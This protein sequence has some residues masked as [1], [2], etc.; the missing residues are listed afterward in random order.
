MLDT[1]TAIDDETDAEIFRAYREWRD[2]ILR[3]AAA[4]EAEACLAR[5]FD[6]WMFM[7]RFRNC[8]LGFYFDESLHDAIA[9][10]NPRRFDT[11]HL[12]RPKTEF[13]IA[14]IVSN[15]V[16]T[17]GASVPHRFMLE[18]PSN[19][20]IQFRQ[21]LLDSNLRDRSDYQETESYRYLKDKVE[22]TEFTHIRAGMSWLEKGEFIQRW[23]HEREIDFVVAAPCPA[24][25][26]A[27]ASRPALIHGILDQNCYCFT[28]GPGAGDLTFL[29]TTDQVFKYQFKRPNAEKHLKIVMLPLHAGDYIDDA[30]PLTRAEIGIPEDTVVS[31]STNLWKTCFG[32]SEVLLE[33]IASLIRH[34]PNFHHVFAGTP[35]CLDN[36]EFFLNKNPDLRGNIHFIGTVRNIYRFLKTVDFWVN[37]FPTAGGSDIECALVG[38]P[39]IE[40]IA[41]RNLNLHGVEFLR[42]RE[43]DVVSLEEFVE[44]GSRFITDAPYRDDLGKFLKTKISREF[45]KQRIVADKIYGS[46]LRAFEAQLDDAPTLPGLDLARSISYEKRIGLYN[47]LGRRHWDAERRWAWLEVCRRDYPE[48]PFAWIKAIEE[49]MAVN[50]E[51][52]LESL[53]AAIDGGLLKDLRIHV[54]L[55]LAFEHFGDS[56]LAIEHALKASGLAIYDETA[57]RVAA[58]LLLKAGRGDEAV[59]LYS[60][61]RNSIAPLVDASPIY[62]DY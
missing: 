17:G 54:M 26:Y 14:F 48:K 40:I 32:D 33:G 12:L 53:V 58:R 30:V 23:L 1:P 7:N 22:L 16:D 49:I 29:L 43:C 20:T 45:D 35:R 2:E 25:L 34:F 9:S 56:K 38:K 11:A 5:V 15:L 47:T 39:T 44:L 18:K 61:A 13:R 50:D 3:H 60:D 6:L 57:R 62:Y 31:G 59:A 24:T 28:L 52:R 8:D 55:A 4:G 36:L 51:K 10:L 27:L 37:S 19:G 41:N 42:S 21:Y 46:F